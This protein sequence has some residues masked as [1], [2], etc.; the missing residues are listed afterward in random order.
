MTKL[1]L[2]HK[3]YP[4]SNNGTGLFQVLVGLKMRDTYER[5]TKVK[6]DTA[7]ASA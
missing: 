5:L 1:L 6:A 2:Q 4:G 3:E 7:S